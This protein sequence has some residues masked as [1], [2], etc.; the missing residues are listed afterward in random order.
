ML[1]KRAAEEQAERG[2]MALVSR[3]SEDIPFGIRALV[4]D[5]DVEGVWNART[6]TSLHCD[7]A[8]RSRKP[9]APPLTPAVKLKTCTS[10]TS[11]SIH[12]TADIGL[13]SPDG[14]CP[15]VTLNSS[16]ILLQL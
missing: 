16:L 12:D 10:T 4:E 3:W 14:Q 5:P 2:E 6:V 13:A 7:S 11:T 8:P 1:E 15:P 9:P